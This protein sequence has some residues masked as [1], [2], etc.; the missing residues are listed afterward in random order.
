MHARVSKSMEE[1]ILP[2]SKNCP[3]YCA[4]CAATTRIL[5][6]FKPS[7]KNSAPPKRPTFYLAIPPTLFGPVVEQLA[8][9]GC[10]KGARIIIEKPFGTDL[11][12]AQ[13][14]Q[15]YLVKRF[16]RERR[17]SE[18][19]ITWGSGR[20]RTCCTSDSQIPFSS[21]SGIAIMSK[22]CRSRWRRSFGVQ[23]R[24]AF[25]DQTGAIRDVVQNHLFQILSN[26]A[27][28]PPARTDSESIRD[29][30]VKVLKAIEPLDAKHVVRGQF[31][32]YRAETR[33]GAR[34]EGGNV[35][36]SASGDP[37]LAVARSSLLHPRRE[38]FAG[39]VH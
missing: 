13:E 5:R 14:A 15:P 25:Y 10:S 17:Y 36:C 35:C 31:R 4:M 1:S 24:G 32:G 38:M 16:L 26:L 33:R 6:R 3:G 19:T 22:A 2:L 39:N 29:E 37:F 11:T 18:S 28:E 23:G 30:K 21:R 8:K 27:M 9:S 20:F 7:A 34:L 12:S